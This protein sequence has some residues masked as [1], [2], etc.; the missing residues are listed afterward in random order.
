MKRLA[1]DENGWTGIKLPVF[2][3][4]PVAKNNIRR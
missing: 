1:A 3:V 4:Y 2:S